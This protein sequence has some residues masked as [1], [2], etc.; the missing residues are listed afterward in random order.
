MMDKD[1]RTL[2][3]LRDKREKSHQLYLANL[4]KAKKYFEKYKQYAF[5][6]ERV[7]EELTA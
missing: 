6:V 1:I 2:T 5:K 3:K 4:H 7:Q